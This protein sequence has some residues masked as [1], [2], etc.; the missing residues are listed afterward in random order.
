MYDF[1]EKEKNALA[2]REFYWFVPNMPTKILEKVLVKIEV[3]LR[4]RD[5][6]KTVLQKCNIL[7]KSS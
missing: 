4:E 6:R 3:E 7:K 1:T 5:L 2:A